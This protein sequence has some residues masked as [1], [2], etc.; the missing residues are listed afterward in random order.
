MKKRLIENGLAHV[1]PR[2]KVFD[3][4]EVSA[5]YSQNLVNTVGL[6]I[7]CKPTD[8]SGAKNACILSNI[9]EI[10]SWIQK[11]M[12]QS[13]GAFEFDQ[14]I[15]GEMYHC[16][17][18]VKNNKILHVQV[19]RYLYPCFD[20]HKGRLCASIVVLPENP[21]YKKSLSFNEIIFNGLQSIPDGVTH[22]EFFKT[23]DD[24]FMFVEI[25]ARPPGVLICP[26]HELNIGLNLKLVHYKL[27]MGL[28]FDLLIQ[29]GFHSAWAT[30]PKKTGKVVRLNYP[31]HLRS[32]FHFE[33]SKDNAT[34][35]RHNL[36]LPSSNILLWNTNYEI[37]EQDLQSLK[38][39]SPTETIED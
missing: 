12:H 14:F 31:N 1:V 37:L 26:A 16:D 13:S 6:P 24:R 28:D 11:N 32:N 36:W 33:H 34:G 3:P 22:H 35:P 23:E 10:S 8:G 9:E 2:F 27:Q 39:F 17:S 5:D 19:F 25:A 20:F 29:P 21:M 18:I 7:F 30:F 4:A 15:T 38:N